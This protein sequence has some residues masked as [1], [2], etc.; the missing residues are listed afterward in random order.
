[1]T[2]IADELR[3][4]ILHYADHGPVGHRAGRFI[5]LKGAALLADYERLRGME[6]R[7]KGAVVAWAFQARDEPAYPGDSMMEVV[8]TED[9]AEQQRQRGYKVT[10][11]VPVPGGE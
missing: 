8:W 3:E 5:R 9:E 11:L 7:V 1:M 6:E 2:D 4:L 10:P